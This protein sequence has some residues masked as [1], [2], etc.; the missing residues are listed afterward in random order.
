LLYKIFKG[1]HEKKQRAKIMKKAITTLA[2]SILTA[3]LLISSTAM[4]FATSDDTPS[5]TNDLIPAPSI[6][7]IPV[8]VQNESIV[9]NV[10]DIT[11][12]ITNDPIPAPSITNTPVEV[13]NE[14]VVE[15]ATD[16]TSDTEHVCTISR[17]NERYHRFDCDE[18]ENYARVNHTEETMT[19]RNNGEFFHI[20]DCEDCGYEYAE[21]HNYRY[22]YNAD[23]HY[24]VCVDCGHKSTATAHTMANYFH[25]WY[26]EIEC[27]ECPA[28]AERHI[29]VTY[30]T[31][32]ATSCQATCDECGVS[33]I[34]P[35][36]WDG[37]ECVNCGFK[38]GMFTTALVVSLEKDEDG[39]YLELL[40]QEYVYIEVSYI[41]RDFNEGDF[42]QIFHDG[43]NIYDIAVIVDG[44]ISYESENFGQYVDSDILANLPEDTKL[45]DL[46]IREVEYEDDMTIIT[47]ESDRMLVVTTPYVVYDMRDSTLYDLYEGNAIL[48]YTLMDGTTVFLVFW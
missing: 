25:G 34:I 20:W 26:H 48:E 13:Q 6:T 37:F 41:E 15:N 4:A 35:H 24:E 17:A 9:E 1:A 14:S 18:C 30:T 8:E 45:Q 23:A 39:Y 3:A 46:V 28:T 32:D 33:E 22:A 5:M 31:I 16:I 2:L 43:N 40:T 12:S 10:T 47:F 38:V 29:G 42:V 21:K 7:D 19:V 11:T 44:Q 27:D 36:E